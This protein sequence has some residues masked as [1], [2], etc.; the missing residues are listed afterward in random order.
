[1]K[2]MRI[3][4]LL[5]LIH[6]LGLSCLGGAIFLQMLVFLDILYQGYFMATEKN[7]IVLSFE[8]ATSFFALAYFVYLYQRSIRSMR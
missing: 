7:I 1:M 4:P 5:I 8:I 2:S 6:S 3:K